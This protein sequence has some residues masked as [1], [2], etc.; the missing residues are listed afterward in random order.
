[1][2]RFRNSPMMHPSMPDSMKPIVLLDGVRTEFPAPTKKLRAPRQRDQ[3]RMVRHALKLTLPTLL[4]TEGPG[5]EWCGRHD[6]DPI[7]EPIYMKQIENGWRA[8]TASFPLCGPG[9]ALDFVP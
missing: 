9:I 3:Q 2:E 5:K 1:M 8:H 7:A 4:T 6:V